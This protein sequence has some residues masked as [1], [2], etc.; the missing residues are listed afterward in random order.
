[1][2]LNNLLIAFPDKTKNVSELPRIF[3]TTFIDTIVETIKMISIST[4]EADKRLVGNIDVL[5]ELYSSGKNVQLLAGHFFNW[6]FLNHWIPRHSLYPFVGVYQPLSNKV[7]DKIIYDMRAKN[8]A[9]LIPTKHF[10]I[11]SGVM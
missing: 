9:I 11:N 5:N 3:I 8:G 1:M 7:M 2:V 6:E 10:K 4:K